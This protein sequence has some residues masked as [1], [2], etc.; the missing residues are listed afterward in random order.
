MI[1]VVLDTNVIVSAV[2]VPAGN[3]AAILL[4]ALRGQIAIYVSEPLL[5]EYEDVLRRPRL[6]LTPHRIEAALSAI[7]MSRTLSRH[8]ARSRFPPTNPTIAFLN[9]LRPPG[10]TTW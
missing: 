10:Q 2:L 7:A 4:L 3:Q 6:K 9:A 1:R 8:A 5:A